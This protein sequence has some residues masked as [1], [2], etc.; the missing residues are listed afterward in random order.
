MRLYRSAGN[1]EAVEALLRE[2]APTLG[3]RALLQGWDLE[4]DAAGRLRL[5]GTVAVGNPL[6]A[7]MWA[8][9][10]E[11]CRLLAGA[12]RCCSPPRLPTEV[13]DQMLSLQQTCVQHVKG[14][15]TSQA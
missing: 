15:S 2:R 14:G 4:P 1:A 12:P 7:V 9:F 6:L 13:V 10:Q 3:R 8:R 11:G 5:P